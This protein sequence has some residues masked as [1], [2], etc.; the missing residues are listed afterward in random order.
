LVR[1]DYTKFSTPLKRRHFSK[2]TK[3]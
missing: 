3:F 1:R 2:M